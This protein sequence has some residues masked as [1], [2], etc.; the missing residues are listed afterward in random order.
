MNAVEDRE[1]PVWVLYHG[2]CQGYERLD[3]CIQ[4]LVDSG[5][6]QCVFSESIEGSADV[7]ILVFQ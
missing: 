7:S 4:L 3:L 6:L 2:L 5:V 1:Y